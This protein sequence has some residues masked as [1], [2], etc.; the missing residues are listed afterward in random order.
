MKAEVAADA[1]A[2]GAAGAE[3]AI[4]R[5]QPIEYRVASSAKAPAT[6]AEAY[7]LQRVDDDVAERVAKALGVDAGDV[8]AETGYGDW[9][10]SGSDPD[11]AVSSSSEAAVDCPADSTCEPPAPPPLVGVP[12]PDDAKAK[13]KEI[14]VALG[15]EVDDADLVVDGEDG[16]FRMV[17]HEPTVGGVPVPV[18]ATSITFGAHSEVQYAN[19]FLFDLDELGRYP[20][21]SLEDAFDRYQSGFGSGSTAVARAATEPAVDAAAADCAADG[22][23]CGAAEPAAEGSTSEGS[24]SAESTGT[25]ASSS[26]ASGSGGGST[27]STGSGSTEPGVAIDPVAPT[28]PAREPAPTLPPRIVEITGARLVLEPVATGCLDDPIYLVPAFELLV[29]D[30]EGGSIGTITAV[31]DEALDTPDPADAEVRDCPEDEV[32]DEPAAKPEPAPAPVP[33]DA[34]SV[35]PQPAPAPRRP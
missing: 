21:V 13:A 35:E 2:A 20:L 27:G 28:E 6:T 4:A 16:R 19:G 1:T 8:D 26:G 25:E 34:G 17:R 30:D 15:Q 29:P 7:Q 24:P 9:Y 5:Y 22:P 14:L 10:S 18:L 3:P 32:V 23:N 11:A 33:P 31:A 12:L